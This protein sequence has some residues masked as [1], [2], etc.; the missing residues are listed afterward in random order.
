MI[1]MIVAGQRELDVLAKRRGEI[2]RGEV[3]A[4]QS[5]RVEIDVIDVF[6]SAGIDSAERRD[7]G[8]ADFAAIRRDAR[9][10]HRQR[11]I[12]RNVVEVVAQPIDHLEA[13]ILVVIFAAIGEVI[14]SGKLGRAQIGHA[15]GIDL[16]RNLL[17]EPLPLV[18]SEMRERDVAAHLVA[19]GVEPDEAPHRVLGAVGQVGIDPHAPRRIARKDLDCAA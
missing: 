10:L 18:H 1:V 4:A 7:L 9:D 19:A 14:G 6:I 11:E 3:V 5:R 12:V 16:V 17:P 8:A 2:E 13:E 15:L